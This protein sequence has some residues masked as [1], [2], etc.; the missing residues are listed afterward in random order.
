MGVLLM[1][2]KVRSDYLPVDKY[3]KRGEG[4]GTWYDNFHKPNIASYKRCDHEPKAIFKIGNTTIWAS[5][6]YGADN[7]NK[8]GLVVSLGVDGPET[9]SLSGEATLVSCL[10]K[11]LKQVQLKFLYIPWNDGSSPPIKST[12]WVAL[13]DSIKNQTIKDVLFHCQGGHGRTGTALSAILIA[14]SGFKPYD[15]ISFV[16]KNH[17]KK[18]VETNSQERYLKDLYKEVVGTKTKV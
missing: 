12:F 6:K 11:H 7:F 17:C 5:D 9:I 10:N 2:G 3:I 1:S 14:V 4:G 15:A 13:F 16:R 8:N 18:C